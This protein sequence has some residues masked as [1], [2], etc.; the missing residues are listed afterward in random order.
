MLGRPAALGVLSV[1]VWIAVAS[2]SAAGQ[3][4]AAASQTP[5]Q[6]DKGRVA[7]GQACAPCHA[8]I[9]RVTQIHRKSADQWRE[10]VFSMIGRG[11]QI[12][13][14]EIE[15]LTA[16]LAATA[17]PNQ[18]RGTTAAAPSDVIAPP[19]DPA[20]T[21]ARAILQRQC[22]RCHDLGT[23]TKRPASSDWKEVVA[24]MVIYGA[25]VTPADQQKLIEYLTVT[26][27]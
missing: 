18:P 10:T 8:N 7:V 17:G 6:I 21:E 20:S 4:I 13:P 23:A 22:T 3:D 26:S 9:L 15:P 14:D 24:R 25:E 1:A 5:A 19:P 11:A 27:K 2:M 12:L 16:F